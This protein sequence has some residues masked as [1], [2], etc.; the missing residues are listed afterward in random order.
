MGFD[1]REGA[2][3][4]L[5]QSLRFRQNKQTIH[6]PMHF[7]KKFQNQIGLLDLA[8]CR[9]VRELSGRCEN[10]QDSIYLQIPCQH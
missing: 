3:Q 8:L 6:D 7:P 1:L 5:V 9:N 10:S 2:E 4:L